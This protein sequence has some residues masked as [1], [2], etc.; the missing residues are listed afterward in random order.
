MT[1][2]IWKTPFGD[3]MVTVQDEDSNTPSFIRCTLDEQDDL[4]IMIPDDE[5]VAPESED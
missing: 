3:K 1:K 2:M 4:P 5:L